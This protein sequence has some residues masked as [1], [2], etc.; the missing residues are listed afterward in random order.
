MTKSLQTFS[1]YASAEFTVKLHALLKSVCFVEVMIR[2]IS[3]K[4]KVVHVA[5]KCG[6]QKRSNAHRQMYE[7]K[8]QAEDIV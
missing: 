7:S 6:E 3:C 5:D 2:V 4:L 1:F 8:Q